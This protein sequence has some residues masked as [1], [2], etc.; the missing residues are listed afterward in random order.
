MPP[1]STVYDVNHEMLVIYPQQHVMNNGTQ[2]VKQTVLLYSD[3]RGVFLTVCLD[4]D[5]QAVFSSPLNSN[6]LSERTIA[7]YRK[8]SISPSEAVQAYAT[9][10]LYRINVQQ[11]GKVE[12]FD[13]AKFTGE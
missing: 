11:N 4:E 3:M 9:Q 8:H 12:R 2:V 7:T 5:N 13:L 1:L 6:D 10:W